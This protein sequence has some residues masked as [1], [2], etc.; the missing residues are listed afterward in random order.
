MSVKVK[1]SDKLVDFITK[2]CEKVHAARKQRDLCNK[3]RGK[4]RIKNEITGKVGEVAA[5]KVCGGKQPDFE[6]YENGRPN[7]DA[8]LGNHIHV[9]TCHLR[10]KGRPL[11]SWTVDKRDPLCFNP[12]PKDVIV[13]VYANE[14][15]D[16]EVVGYVN[17]T[18]VKPYWRPTRNLYHKLAIYRSDIKEF[19]QLP[20]KL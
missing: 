19:I 6:I 14:Y 11:D 8:D 12:H 4:Q 1:L 17:A 18:D 9:K 16:N 2:F 3:D 10:Y 15:G 20:K 5:W 7:F 13:L